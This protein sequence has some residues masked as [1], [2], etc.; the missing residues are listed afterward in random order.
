MSYFIGI[1]L[2]TSA[3]KLVLTDGGGVPVR[4]EK[5]SYPVFAPHPG[6]SEQNPEDWWTA[7]REGL[8]A[9][10]AGL[11]AGAVEGL[12]VG[13]QMHGLVLLGE[14]DEPLTPA[15]LWND[16]RTGTETDL[17]NAS[18]PGKEKLREYTGNVAFAGFTAPKVLWVRRHL[19]DVWKKVR[20]ACLPKDYLNLK[21]TGV[22]ATDVS[23]AS[24]T[25]YFDVRNRRW[26]KEM[27]SILGLE[28][29]MLPKV[30]ESGE[31]IGVLKP[32][33]GLGTGVAVAAGAGDN[34]AAAVGTNTVEKGRC[35]VSV[36]TSGTVFLPTERFVLPGNEALHSFCHANGAWHLM[37]CILSAAGAN[38]WLTET[39]FGTTDYASVSPDLTEETAKNPLFFLPYL[40]GE[41][42]PHNDPAARGAFLG[43]TPQTDRKA[44]VLSLFEGVSFAL[45]DCMELAPDRLAEVT[46]CG[47]GTKSGVWM[48]VLSA[49]LNTK[50]TVIENE[51]PALG[52]AVLGAR[53][54]GKTVV[55]PVKVRGEVAPDPAL[56]AI[57]EAKYAKFRSLYPLLKEFY[58]TL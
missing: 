10:T 7:V 11:P 25:L 22:F 2:G 24:G 26:S 55:P 5:R 32:E 52:G 47:G 8:A 41:R 28:E 50:L 12:G 17:L 14:G 16:A 3:V 43:L 9:L 18:A 34:A 40:S 6:W 30:F 49:V 21:L 51:G 13:G 56:A 33:F 42:C 53:A 4:E 15:I 46:V 19:P 29:E 39:V 35:N 57:Y 58:Q 31:K 45:R 27:L 44:L 1:D 54:A 38:A 23:D 37:G 36:G 48:R 20:R